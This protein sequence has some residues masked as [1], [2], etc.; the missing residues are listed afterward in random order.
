[1]RDSDCDSDSDESVCVY[2]ANVK[3]GH[4]VPSSQH[5]KHDLLNSSTQIEHSEGK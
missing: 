2:A 4:I 3:R 1:M 5:N